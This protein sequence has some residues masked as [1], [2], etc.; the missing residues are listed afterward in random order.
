M[1]MA[2]EKA[3]LRQTEPSFAVYKFNC[4]LTGRMSR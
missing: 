4:V 2:A 3:G 1:D